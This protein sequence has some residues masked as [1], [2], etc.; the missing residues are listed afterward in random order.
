MLLCHHSSEL[1]LPAPMKRPENV[2]ALPNADA[3]PS[4]PVSLPSAARQNSNH[5]LLSKVSPRLNPLL[6]LPT[7]DCVL[8]C[9]PYKSEWPAPLYGFPGSPTP[10][11]AVASPWKAPGAGCPS[12]APPERQH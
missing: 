6:L 11:L 12:L 1:L 7:V 8:P 10:S 3:C 5:L 2:A 9:P 4:I